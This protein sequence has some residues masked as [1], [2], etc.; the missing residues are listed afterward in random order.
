LPRA[1][2][3]EAFTRTTVELVVSEARQE[4]A[5]EQAALPL[6]KRRRWIAAA[7][8][9]LAA[10]MVGFIA[11]V[12][13]WPDENERLLRDLPVVQNYELYDV[14][15]QS[16]GIKFLR[17]L[18]STDLFVGDTA[19]VNSST[20][21]RTK[22]QADGS[23]TREEL[24]A[25]REE[26]E[27]LSLEEKNDLR[28]SYERFRAQPKEEQERLRDF[29][30]ALRAEPDEARLRGVLAS[31]HNWLPT[32]SPLE[33]ANL[34][35]M[36]PDNAIKEIQRLKQEQLRVFARSGG[37]RQGPLEKSDVDKIER[38][39]QDWAWNQRDDILAQATPED[40]EWFRKLP[41]DVKRRSL[42]HLTKK[43]GPPRPPDLNDKEWQDLLGQ[44]PTVKALFESQGKQVPGKLLQ[45]FPAE[46]QE[47]IKAAVSKADTT[48]EKQNVLFGWYHSAQW[49][50]DAFAGGVSRE[51]LDRFFREE[52]D[53]KERERLLSRAPEDFNKSLRFLY[54]VK[55][56][57]PPGH[58]RG[59]GKRGGGRGGKGDGHGPG[60]GFGRRGPPEFDRE[61]HRRRG[62][63]NDD[64]R[65]E[66]NQGE[67]R[68]DD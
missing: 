41:D 42:I 7:V 38:F 43:P 1:A 36:S 66:R 5:A 11:V 48:K 34:L 58:F 59:F 65:H 33:R 30:A 56:E 54:F 24:A 13:A 14:T 63:D 4:I 9:G 32:L 68:G 62:D 12:F 23:L 52:L 26:V 25:R 55:K 3:D 22:T 44:L 28:K 37:S 21:E 19:E 2:L 47:G 60:N 17:D 31:Y 27:S 6:R 40:Q 49:A 29:D 51:E 61:R 39:L 50:R 15:P 46:V 45:Q 53:Q 64:R 18:E 20:A 67:E 57:L 16:G 8:A 10:A 35:K